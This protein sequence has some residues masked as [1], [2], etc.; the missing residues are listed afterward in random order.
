[1]QHQSIDVFRGPKLLKVTGADKLGR[2]YSES[3][4]KVRYKN[5]AADFLGFNCSY[6]AMEEFNFDTFC[7]LQILWICYS[8][9]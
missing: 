5:N 9:E 6:F 2:C 1:M 7:C 3:R 4:K 8:I